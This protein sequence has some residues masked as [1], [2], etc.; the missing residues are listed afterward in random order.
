MIIVLTASKALTILLFLLVWI[1]LQNGFSPV[2]AA[3]SNGHLEVLKLLEKHN[4][5]LL[6]TDY[7][8]VR[9]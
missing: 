8:K 7:A 9:R 5:D 2:L 3:S 4:G 1:Y 6:H